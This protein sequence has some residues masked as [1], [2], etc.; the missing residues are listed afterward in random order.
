MITLSP[1]AVFFKSAPLRC[2]SC[3]LEWQDHPGIAATC[4]AKE[5]L[6]EA[7]RAVLPYCRPPEGNGSEEFVEY[8]QIVKRAEKLLEE[9]A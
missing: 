5:N 4:E 3:D 1:A 6:Y 2:Q 7:L 8:F 9:F